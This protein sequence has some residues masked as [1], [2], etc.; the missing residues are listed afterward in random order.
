MALYGLLKFLVL[1]QL[2]CYYDSLIQRRSF[3][4]QTNGKEVVV[5]Y[6]K[7]LTLDLSEDKKPGGRGLCQTY[8]TK[9]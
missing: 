2:P 4:C 3:S 5:D 7:V 1:N 9:R 8:Y 6:M